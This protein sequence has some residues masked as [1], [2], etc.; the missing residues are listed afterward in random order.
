MCSKKWAIPCL[1]LKNNLGFFKNIVI[2]TCSGSSRHP[3]STFMAPALLS[4][5]N[6]YSMVYF[7]FTKKC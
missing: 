2:F 3:T 1:Y 5:S 4:H 7:Y 6:I